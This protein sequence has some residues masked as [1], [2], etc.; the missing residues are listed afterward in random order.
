MN[1]RKPAIEKLEQAIQIA[2]QRV[3]K[4][5][6]EKKAPIAAAVLYCLA[7]ETQAERDSATIWKNSAPPSR[8]RPLL[9]PLPEHCKRTAATSKGKNV[10]NSHRL[11][12]THKIS[13]KKV[14]FSRR[15]PA[16]D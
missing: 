9:Q 2:G 16:V 8:N 10:K 13:I 3:G 7:A 5:S 6:A 1:A 11:G 12:S 15:N 14:H 4:G